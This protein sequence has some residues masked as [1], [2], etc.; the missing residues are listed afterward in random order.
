VKKQLFTPGKGL[1]KVKKPLKRP[2]DG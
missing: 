1:K 2:K